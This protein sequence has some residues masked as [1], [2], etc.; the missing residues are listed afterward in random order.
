MPLKSNIPVK[1]QYVKIFKLTKSTNEKL[2]NYLLECSVPSNHHDQFE[3]MS[4]STT[5]YNF[6]V[7]YNSKILVQSIDLNTFP[8]NNSYDILISAFNILS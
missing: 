3:S 1:D 5:L 4:N 2:H 7:S 6:V 8:H